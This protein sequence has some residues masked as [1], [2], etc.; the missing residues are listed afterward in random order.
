MSGEVH[1]R[2]C[3][4]LGVQ[5]PGLLTIRE[6]LN[7]LMELV[8][9]ETLRGRYVR[10]VEVLSQL[11]DLQNE[12]SEEAENMA[13]VYDMERDIRF[14]QG[15]V[16]GERKGLLEGERKGLLE[17]ERRGLLEG[18][19][20]GL[21]EGIELGLELK[22]GSAGVELMDVVCIIPT[23]DKLEEFKNLIRR[24]DSLDE[25]KLFLGKAYKMPNGD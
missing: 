19:R 18:E 7:R 11:R 24:A 23:V 25:L 10:Q 21:L 8:P 3:E 12:V 5:F 13:I 1:V 6:I 9:E 14:R 20:R 4:G 16:E 22:Y 2:F 17:G 15:L